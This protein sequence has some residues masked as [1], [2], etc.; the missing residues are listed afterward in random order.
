MHKRALVRG[1]R[2]A[3]AHYLAMLKQLVTCGL[4]PDKCAPCSPAH[5]PCL[6]LVVTVPAQLSP[7]LHWALL[8]LAAS[9]LQPKRL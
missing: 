4:L 5:V 3:G 7:A 8:A 1:P 2:S 9:T 6:S